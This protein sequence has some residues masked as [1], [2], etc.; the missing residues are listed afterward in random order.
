MPELPQLCRQL[1]YIANLRKTPEL[2]QTCQQLACI[3]NLR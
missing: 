2:P 3:A 1:A